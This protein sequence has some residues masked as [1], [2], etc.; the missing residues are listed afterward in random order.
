MTLFKRV[1]ISAKLPLVMVLLTASAVIAM[2]TV[3]FIS[4]RAMLIEATRGQM[5]TAADKSAAAVAQFFYEIERN[6]TLE[7]QSPLVAEA[8]VAFANAF[9]RVADPVE[10]LQRAYIDDNPHPLGEKDKLLTAATGSAYDAVHAR[11]HLFFDRLQDAYGY[12]DVFLFDTA[13][14]LVYSVFKE[15]DYATNMATGEWRQTGLAAVTMEALSQAPGAATAFRDFAPY[16]PSADAPAS[17]MARPIFDASGVRVGVL[18][19]QM[20]IDAINAAVRGDTLMETSDAFIV[21]QDGLLRTDARGTEAD[22]ILATR[23]DNPVVAAALRG[24]A[25][26][27]YFTDLTGAEA[28]WI[29][30]AENVL[31]VDW[32]VVTEVDT[33]ELYAPLAALWRSFL[34]QGAVLFAVTLGVALLMSRGITRPLSALGRAMKDIAED[35]LETTVPATDRGDEIGAMAGTLEQLRQTLLAGVEVAREATFKGAGFEKSAAPM[36]LTDTEFNIIHINPALEKLMEDRKAD[37]A[38]VIENFDPKALLGKNMDHFHAIPGKARTRLSRPENLPVKLR[39]AV[40]DAVVGL[41]VD[42]VHDRSGTLVGYVLDWKDQTYTSHSQVVINAID[43]RQVR[44]ETR[45]DGTVHTVNKTLCS[46][47][48]T[49]DSAVIGRS[50]FDI[51]AIQGAAPDAP[52]VWDEVRAGRSVFGLFRMAIGD[53]ARLV[54]GSL[55][56]LPNARGEPNGFLLIAADVTEEQTALA[57]AEAKRKAVAE[58]Q[59]VVVDGLRQGLMRLSEGDLT[60]RL[61]T[62]FASEYEQL[63]QD[64]NDAMARLLEAIQAAVANSDQI[65]TE[66]IE[67]TSAVG[68][69]S[70][71]TE[72]QA[73]TLEQTAAALDELTSSVRSAADGARKAAEIVNDA[74]SSAEQ[75]GTVVKEAFSAMGEIETSS[76]EISKIISVIDDIAFQTNLLALNAGVE[77]AR[78]G[79]AGRGF[80]VVAS[81]VRAL[82][83]RSSDAA[84][85]INNLI[86][87]SGG[88]VKRGVSLV[89]DAGDALKRIVASV[90]EIDEHVGEI[91]RSSAEQSTGLGEINTA[92]NQLDQAT[93][94]NAAM[95]E[96]TTAA[97]HSLT[98]EAETLAETMA[99]FR[100]GDNAALRPAGHAPAKGSPAPQ[101]PKTAAAGSTLQVAAAR[102][103]V[104]GT[105]EKGRA[106]AAVGAGSERPLPV[107]GNAALAAPAADDWEEF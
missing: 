10:T 99:R 95:V 72:S 7:A 63:R 60:V 62:E 68:D 66:S 13:G 28:F 53:T 5:S 29:A 18:A 37:F 55:S 34:M 9:E 6:L 38:T 27:G 70:K 96:Q 89:G 82:A 12:Y 22:D 26:E 98:S 42:A 90:A 4:S 1:P 71:R 40:G 106:A 33:A 36:V 57:E 93:Q 78:A 61:D 56:V 41:L 39:I 103:P 23:V 69:L 58:A 107:Q 19:Y 15:R 35:R 14:N 76:R 75:S 51:L 77:A 88:H 85:E 79:D 49:D 64:F 65:R 94:H 102:A 32:A 87:A 2:G 54:R 59:R 44:M 97:S 105:K 16:G 47:F 92:V 24:N 8:V 104:S 30:R 46:V 20:P 52:P 50:A 25:G 48:D 100:I 74:R 67:I 21:G 3:S 45:L 43:A 11:Y 80:A 31:G 91:A 81:E 83:Q 73:A 17:F 101:A 84:R 86:T